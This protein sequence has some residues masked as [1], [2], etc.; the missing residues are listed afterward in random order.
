MVP[1]DALKLSYPDFVTTPISPP[2]SCLWSSGKEIRADQRR[3]NCTRYGVLTKNAFSGSD[4]HSDRLLTGKR[5]GAN[6][7]TK[8]QNRDLVPN[9]SQTTPWATPKPPLTCVG[10]TGFEPATAGPQSSAL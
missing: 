9:W 5:L 6:R 2:S 4:T 3:K 7:L 8:P 1:P 10:L